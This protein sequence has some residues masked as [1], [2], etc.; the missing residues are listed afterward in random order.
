MNG[1]NKGA[2]ITTVIRG[3]SAYRADL[4]EDDVVLRIGTD[5]IADAKA[6]KDIL[7]KYYGKDG[8]AFEIIRKGTRIVKMVGIDEA[9]K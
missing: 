4:L 5:D 1:T 7:P 8:V 2:M 9:Y 3:T 6:M